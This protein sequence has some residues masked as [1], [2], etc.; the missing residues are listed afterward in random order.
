[1]SIDLTSYGAPV[2]QPRPAAPLVTAAE[3]QTLTL[4]LRKVAGPRV[5]DPMTGVL[6]VRDVITVAPSDMLR[7]HLAP[8]VGQPM[9]ITF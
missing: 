2:Q 6:S 8:T 7:L 5:A 4:Q 9:T 3:G 1:M